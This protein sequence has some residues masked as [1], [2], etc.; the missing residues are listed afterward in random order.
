MRSMSGGTHPARSLIPAPQ[1]TVELRAS[2]R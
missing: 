1:L 2:R